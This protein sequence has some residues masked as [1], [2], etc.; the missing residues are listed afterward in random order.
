[1]GDG[2]RAEVA[3]FVAIYSAIGLRDEEIG[4][5]LGLAMRRTSFPNLT[6]LRRDRHESTPDCWL[7]ADGFCLS[8]A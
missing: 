5:R 2:F 6:H 4:S 7:H 8:M 3:S 1:S